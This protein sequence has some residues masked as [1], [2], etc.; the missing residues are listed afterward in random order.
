MESKPCT[1]THSIAL[2][3]SNYL[4]SSSTKCYDF[5]SAQGEGKGCEQSQSKYGQNT[6]YQHIDISALRHR[7]EIIG[8]IL[9]N[10]AIMVLYP[11]ISHGLASNPSPFLEGLR[12]AK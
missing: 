9:D 3:A 5:Q 2:H 10:T 8:T 1:D 4:S 11:V 12:H 7:I 6:G